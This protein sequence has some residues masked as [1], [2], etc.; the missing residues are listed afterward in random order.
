[1]DHRRGFSLA[2]PARVHFHSAMLTTERWRAI[3]LALAAI[4]VAINTLHVLN[5]NKGGDADVFFEGGRRLLHGQSLY[6][7]SSAAAGFIGPPFQ[8]VFFAPFAAIDAVNRQLARLLWY[9]VNLIC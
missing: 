1:M 9:A 8:A 7:G 2:P 5:P 3:A 4:F 6:E